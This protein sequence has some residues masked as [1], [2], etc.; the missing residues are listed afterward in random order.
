MATGQAAVITSRCPVRITST[1]G[2]PQRLAQ[3]RR[4]EGAGDP[5]SA[6]MALKG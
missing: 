2:V 1:V 5:S 4:G 3:V 6:G